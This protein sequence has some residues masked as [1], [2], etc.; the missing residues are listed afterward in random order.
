MERA[1]DSLIPVYIWTS[2][3]FDDMANYLQRGA[4]G[5]ITDMPDLARTEIDEYLKKIKNILCTRG[6]GILFSRN[7]K[8][9][10]V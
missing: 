4:S 2:N 9:L 8:H 5:I 3:N 10:Q 6:K 1:R 7:L